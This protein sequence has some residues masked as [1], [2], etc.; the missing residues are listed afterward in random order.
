MDIKRL[1]LFADIA[2]TQNL[3]LTGERMGYTQS[4][5]SHLIKKLEEEF[6]F[7][8]FERTNKGA[9]LTAYG[10]IML[11]YVRSLIAQYS[12]M[13]ETV[14]SLNGLQKG[15]LTVG[16]YSSTAIHWLP[17][18]IRKFQSDYPGITLQIKEGGIEE[19]E[20]WIDNG[21]VDLAFMSK[22]PHHHFDWISLREDPL[23]AVLPASF[24]L[25]EDAT[26]FPIRRFKDLPYISSEAGVDYDISST[27]EKN[28]IT[29]HIKFSCKDDHSII[30]MVAKELG[31]SILPSLLVEG[32]TEE[33]KV[34]PLKP[35]AA[36]ELGIGMLSKE[37]LSPA[38]RAFIKCAQLEIGA[39]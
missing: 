30:A 22:S 34:L 19:L 26:V 29:P 37:S 20:Q 39:I 21:I 16:T 36:R 15:H 31:V 6:G 35:F 12:T 3:T 8:L 1:E 4:G 11:P 32:Y 14:D 7:P 27:L 9:V 25:E 38:T 10:K 23:L 33:L 5:V 24:P 28:K 18:I 13:Q 2:Q 17:S